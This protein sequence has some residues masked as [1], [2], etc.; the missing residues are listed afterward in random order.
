MALN[1]ITGESLP[2]NASAWNDWYEQHGAEKI[3]QFE[4]QDSWLVRGDE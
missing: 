3:A 4:Q 2:P 1:E